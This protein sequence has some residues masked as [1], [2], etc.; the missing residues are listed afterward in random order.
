MHLAESLQSRR[1]LLRLAGS[2]PVIGHQAWEW[3]DGPRLTVGL[4]ESRANGACSA[5]VLTISLIGK[6]F[7]TRC[8]PA[9]DSGPRLGTGSPAS[10][11]DQLPA[12]I[13]VF[14]SNMTSSS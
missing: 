6:L 8:H 4:I 12:R 14:G 1:V 11:F 9:R 2:G 7:H 10:P 13:A 5:L 3:G